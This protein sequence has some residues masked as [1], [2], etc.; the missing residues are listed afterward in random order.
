[1]SFSRFSR[2]SPCESQNVPTKTRFCN[3]VGMNFGFFAPLRWPNIPTKIRFCILV[4]IQSSKFAW[5]SRK[6][7]LLFFI[8]AIQQVR[9]AITHSRN[10][11]TNLRF[12]ILV[13]RTYRPNREKFIWDGINRL[14]IPSAI[15]SQLQKSALGR[16]KTGENT[17][18][19]P[20]AI[21]SQL[22][23]THLGRCQ[24][25][26]KQKNKPKNTVPNGKNRI[27]TVRRQHP[28]PN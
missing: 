1:M 22:R 12:S 21:P 8:F 24:T 28:T 5:K 13:G 3:L 11:P 26:E 4:G 7:Y 16:Y 25:P 18:Q 15:P 10:I 20:S 19:K 6:R 2:H 17:S 9:S 14:T 27:G 23:K